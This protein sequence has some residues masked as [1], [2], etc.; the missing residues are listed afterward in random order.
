MRNKLI[1]A[2]VVSFLGMITTAQNQ[3][4]GHLQKSEYKISDERHILL[5]EGFFYDAGGSENDAGIEE[6]VTTLHAEVGYLS[7]N[8][9]YIDLP[10]GAELWIFE[11]KST[12]EQPI[13]VAFA[14]DKIPTIEGSHLTF[15]YKPPVF[16]DG[17]DAPGWKA[18]VEEKYVVY[19]KNDKATWPE[20]DCPFAIPL[21]DNSSVMTGLEQ[22]TD[23]G[24][25][26][27]D[28]GTCYSGTGSGGSVWY[29]FSPETDGPL[30]FTITPTSSTDYD[31]VL[32]D[33]T[34][35]CASGER[36]QMSCN[37]SLYTGPTGLH[38]SN[39]GQVEGD[40]MG[41]CSTDSKG[42]SYNRW[43]RRKN[44]LTT[45]RYAICVNFYSG[46]NHGFTMNFQQQSGSVSIGDNSNPYILNSYTGTCTLPTTIHIEFNEWVDCSTIQGSDFN[47]PGY[48]FTVIDDHCQSGRTLSVDLSVSPAIASGSYNITVTGITDMCGNVMNSVYPIIIG[49]P[50][51]A[52][53][54]PNKVTCKKPGFLGIGWTYSPSSQTISGSSTGGT[55]YQWSNG[56]NTQNITVSPTTTTTYYLTVSNS[57]CYSVDSVT[58]YVDQATANAGP[59]QTMCAGF[60]TNL[61]A[62]GGGTY[63]WSTGATT[64]TISVA[65]GVTTTYRVTV[66]TANGCTASDAVIV[67]IGSGA[68]SATASPPTICSGSSSTLSLPAAITA[69]EWTGGP[70]NSPWIVTPGSTTTYT[71]TSTTVGCTGTTSVTVYVNPL[72]SVSASFLPDPICPGDLMNLSSLPSTGGTTW[73]ENFEA[74]NGFTLI[75]G[76]YNRWRT[77][78]ATSCNGTQSL[79]I[80]ETNV[81]TTYNYINFSGFS[82]RAASNFAYR[83][84]AITGYSQADLNFN[85]RC[86][87]KATDHLTV[88][89]IPTTTIPVAGTALTVT[90]GNVRLGGPYWNSAGSCNPVSIDLRQ[91]AGTTIRLVFQWTNTAGSLFSGN[92]AA[93]PP[94][95][96][97]DIQIIQNNIY[98]YAWSTAPAGFS[99]TNQNP[100][101]TALANTTYTVTVTRTDGCANTASVFV[102]DCVVPVELLFLKGYSREKDNLLVWATASELNNAY[103][104]IER[105]VN[106]SDFIHIGKVNGAGNSNSYIE[107]TLQDVYPLES[108]YYRLKQTDFDGSFVYSEVIFLER[109]QSTPVFD[110]VIWP[111]PASD[112]LSMAY[113]LGS[114]DVITVYI[115]DAI[116]RIVKGYTF[117]SSKGEN[118]QNL[119]IT[120][121]E[122][123]IYYISVRNQNSDSKIKFVK[124]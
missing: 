30:D 104:D 122:N 22:Y 40:D 67:N 120:N 27:D 23:L 107:Y 57:G 14:G 95:S 46:S 43:N 10:Q 101:T 105:S 119:D 109:N 17:N 13:A 82:G 25:I 91:F 28:S 61:T 88:W 74:G 106:G 34:N 75:N 1:I 26:N 35:G 6:F 21:C 76:T 38:D 89:A 66:T 2:I 36:V 18:V 118:Y 98:S 50:V 96:I 15:W 60:S 86:L 33:I 24:N 72:P 29:A 87:G 65:P 80:T 70:V 94:A 52:E 100:S 54:G 19:D 110:V 73:S 108:A 16:F 78:T 62:S 81:S 4:Q 84:V 115:C 48:T 90:G 8:F 31:F 11:G 79:F 116:G 47:L 53:A 20:S 39:C 58:V 56:M 114:D 92:T 9:E 5:H 121:L 64:Q 45:H 103:F 93:P 102:G 42:S 7:I 49:T 41:D 117:E 99:S 12:D 68:F 124:Q 44:V 37:Y 55:Q 59:D 97:D 111:N 83:D 71:V 112:Q 69:Y 51:T 77:G 3:P 113:S 63:V 85:W 32:W 123:G